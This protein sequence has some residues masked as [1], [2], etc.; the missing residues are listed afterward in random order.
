MKYD[1]FRLRVISALG[2]ILDDV[3]N[4]INIFKEGS[5]D[6]KYLDIL[7]NI[8]SRTTKTVRELDIKCKKEEVISE[9]KRFIKDIDASSVETRR[10]RKELRG[11]F[12]DK[13][14]IKRIPQQE[15]I[16]LISV[17]ES[18]LKV[19]YV[20]DY[21]GPNSMLKPTLEKYNLVE[22][23][24]DITTEYKVY[25]KFFEKEILFLK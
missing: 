24:T 12:I 11:P 8:L 7:E 2:V 22:F 25:Q 14:E 17:Q 16:Q 23:I 18:F 9:I 1:R 15:Y 6:K 13:A 3:E 5:L 20:L 4:Q 10:K 21:L 19:L